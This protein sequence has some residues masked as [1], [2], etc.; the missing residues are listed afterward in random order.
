MLAPSSKVKAPVPLSKV[1]W[2]VALD[3]N[4]WEPWGLATNS[5]TDSRD[6][7]GHRG[8]LGNWAAMGYL[9]LCPPSPHPGAP[10][11]GVPPKPGRTLS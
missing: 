9:C 3:P 5:T 1:S 2:V 11:V 4:Y 6:T 10:E 8:C 7:W